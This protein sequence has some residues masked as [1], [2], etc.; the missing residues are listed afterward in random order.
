MRT[1]LEVGVCGIGAAVG[2]GALWAFGAP[3]GPWSAAALVLAVWGFA[4]TCLVGGPLS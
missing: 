1:A 4:A 3:L 2:V